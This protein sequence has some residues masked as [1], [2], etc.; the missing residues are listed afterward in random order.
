MKYFM[1]IVR[2]VSDTDGIYDT[3]EKREIRKGEEFYTKEDKLYLVDLNGAHLK[4]EK[5]NKI[6]YYDFDTGEIIAM[7]KIDHPSRF[8]EPKKLDMFVKKKILQQLWGRIREQG[9]GSS[10]WIVFL[11]MGIGIGIAIG[12]I[13][14]HFITPT[15]PV[16]I[17]QNS[18]TPI[19]S[20]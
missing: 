7:K 12:I 19:P 6:Y 17:V 9:T 16:V 11:I 13:V 14:G 15:P 5:G 20:I 1:Q 4:D 18:T 3:I 10:S 2:T 8:Y